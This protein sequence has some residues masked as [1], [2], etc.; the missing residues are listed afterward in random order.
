MPPELIE[1]P[2]SELHVGDIIGEGERVAWMLKNEIQVAVALCSFN[3][4][5]VPNHSRY[6][7]CD[8]LVKVIRGDRD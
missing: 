1:I 4:K 6:Y 3:G 2:A 5:D 7:Y 8:E